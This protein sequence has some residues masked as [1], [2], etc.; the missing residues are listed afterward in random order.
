MR[1]LIIVGVVG[2]G[3]AAWG[4]TW[5]VRKLTVAIDDINLEEIREER[6]VYYEWEGQ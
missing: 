1:N 4:W 2:L 6:G 5:L 3:C